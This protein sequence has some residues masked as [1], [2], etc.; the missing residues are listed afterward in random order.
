MD[1]LKNEWCDLSWTRWVKFDAPRSEF[2]RI[3]KFSGVYRVKPID[4]DFLMYIGQTGRTLRQRLSELRRYRN[5]KEMP[6]NDPHTAAP[7]LW[8]WRDATG[9]DF[10]CSASAIS[11]SGE[12]DL[13]LE[14]R[15]RE[16]LECYLLWQYRIEYGS[17]TLC[18]FGRFHPNYVKSRNQKSGKRGERLAEGE[19]NPAGGPSYPPLHPK[20]EPRDHD[21]MNLE[22]SE[23]FQLN[24]HLLK[25][26]PDSP[27]LYKIIDFDEESLVYLGQSINLKKRL[28]QHAKKGWD[29]RIVSFSYYVPDRYLLPHQLKEIENDLIGDYF[30]RFKTV[31]KYQF[32]NY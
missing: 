21:W 5:S 14:R 16:G 20:G 1:F 25:N 15:K 13:R 32:L 29:D 24:I 30:S 7:S 22:W 23:M 3:P 4:E 17:S 28:Q 19:I 8:A 31:P 11:L 6:Y 9:M 27:G 26:I 12:D 10:E 18:N 2:N